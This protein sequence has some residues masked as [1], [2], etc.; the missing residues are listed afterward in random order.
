M[1]VRIRDDVT[2]SIKRMQRQLDLLPKELHALVVK[3][4]PIR[5]GNARKKT[6]LTRNHTR[7]E[8]DYAYAQPLNNGHSPQAPKGFIKPSLDWLKKRFRQ[9]IRGGR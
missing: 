6:Y 8:S 7:I 5:T 3:N 2:P 9:I 1:T 4:T